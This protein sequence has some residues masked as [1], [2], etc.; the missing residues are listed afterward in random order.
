MDEVDGLM[1]NAFRMTPKKKKKSTME[2]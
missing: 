1:M 2:K